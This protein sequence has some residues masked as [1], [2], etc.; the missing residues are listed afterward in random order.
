MALA[1]VRCILFQTP[2]ADMAEKYSGKLVAELSKASGVNE[3]DVHKVLEQLGLSRIMA[4]A[5]KSN[6]GVEPSAAAA[7]IGFKIGKSTI[8]V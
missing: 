3:H 4:E 7:K 8:V 5:V 6:G 2:E 1:A